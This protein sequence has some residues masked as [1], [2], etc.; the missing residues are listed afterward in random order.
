MNVKGKIDADDWERLLQRGLGQSKGA[1][2]ITERLTTSVQGPPDPL[3]IRRAETI[4]V[5]G[6]LTDAQSELLERILGTVENSKT[7]VVGQ[8]VSAATLAVPVLDDI[9][10]KCKIDLLSNPDTT[11]ESLGLDHL[12]VRCA[13]GH[14][15]RDI[16]RWLFK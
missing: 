7:V 12:T 5:E 13:C 6:T 15:S 8:P 9:C 2:S 10:P 3:N 14:V 11:V 4:T 1:R 16:P